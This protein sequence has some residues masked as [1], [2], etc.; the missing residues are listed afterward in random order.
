MAHIVMAV[1]V[2]HLPFLCTD[3]VGKM[4]TQIS[5]HMS[6]HTPI[7][8]FIH[9]SMHMPIHMSTHTFLQ[10][11]VC[12]RIQKETI[13][14]LFNKAVGRVVKRPFQPATTGSVS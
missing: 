10:T 2:A 11:H 6:T 8:M 3:T 5:I 7:H 14:H 12:A 1:G 13:A 4:S 9:T